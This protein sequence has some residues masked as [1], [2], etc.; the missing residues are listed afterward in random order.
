MTSAA[1]SLVGAAPPPG[2]PVDR[3]DPG[4][5]PLPFASP[6]PTVTL[7]REEST[8]HPFALTIAAAW[9]C[10]GGRPAKVETVQKL[11]YGPEPEGLSPV[12]AADRAH[13]R[14]R[15]MKL[16][17]DLF[18]AGHHT[19]LQH[20]NFVFVLDN[21]SRL[22]IWSF[23]HAHPFYNS[24]Q[25]SQRYREVTGE[26]MVTPAL[27]EPE[28][29]IYR[30]AIARSLE[31]YRRLTELLTPDMAER[32]AR[33]FPARA[34]AKGPEAERRVADAVQKRAQEVARYVLPLATPAH[35]YHTVNGLTLLRYHV[36]ANQPDAPTEVRYVVRRMVEE[37]LAVDPYFLGAPAHPL[38][39][40]PLGAE[41]SLEA[42]AL[43]DWRATLAQTEAETEAFC[44]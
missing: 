36:L 4:G 19:T 35:L 5:E 26:T 34:K 10:Y 28:L 13:R 24:E 22:A 37:V 27:P 15:A 7:L 17:A 40:R 44:R 3:P 21:V 8:Q 18:A 33:V 2:D 30:G 42:R 6:P 32:Y 29:A 38:D 16:Y 11:V 14:E 12:K 39:L 25:V 41:E 9:S 43:A 1:A 20:A 23:F 31:G